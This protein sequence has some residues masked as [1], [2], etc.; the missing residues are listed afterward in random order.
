MR[1]SD[2]I[3]RCERYNCNAS[4]HSEKLSV[5]AGDNNN[6]TIGAGA[7]QYVV[8]ISQDAAKCKITLVNKTRLLDVLLGD[9][10]IR[11]RKSPWPHN[12]RENILQKYLTLWRFIWFNQ[13]VF[14]VVCNEPGSRLIRNLS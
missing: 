7:G 9:F 11:N 3:Q 8:R 6:V 2:F 14:V 1:L 10:I 5:G 4:Y 12:N 13:S